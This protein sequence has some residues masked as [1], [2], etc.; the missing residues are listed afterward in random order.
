MISTFLFQLGCGCLWMIG[1]CRTDQVSWKYV[2]LMGV[3]AAVLIACGGGAILLVPNWSVHTAARLALGFG[4]AGG[5]AALILLIVNGVQRDRPRTVQRIIAVLGGVIALAAAHAMAPGATRQSLDPSVVRAASTPGAAAREV[6]PWADEFSARDAATGAGVV[7]GVVPWIQLALGSIVLGGVTAGMLLG[8]AYLTQTTMPIDPLRRLSRALSLAVG[9]R[10]V[11]VAAILAMEWAR[12]DSTGPD[13]V[14]LWL[15]LAVRV[16][17]GLVAL[18]LLAYMI[19]DCVQ[20]R[21]TQ[22]ATGILYIAM[23]LAFLGELSAAE[24]ARSFNLWL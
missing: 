12:L 21:S 18:G 10:A 7:P 5:L 14:W 20:R 4:V 15:M 23:V 1:L 3:V 17:V 8:H 13:V 16:G 9:V 22:S 6:A 2:R 24:L 11:W 19:S